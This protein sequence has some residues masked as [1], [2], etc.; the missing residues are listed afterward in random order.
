MSKNGKVKRLKMGLLV[1]GGIVLA[2]LAVVGTFLL[3]SESDEDTAKFETAAGTPGPEIAAARPKRIEISLPSHPIYIGGTKASQSID[4]V[5]LHLVIDEAS[6]KNFVCNRL[7][8]IKD[9]LSVSFGGKEFAGAD[10]KAFLAPRMANIIRRRI[11]RALNTD[12]VRDVTLSFGFQS[13]GRAAGCKSTA[14]K[15]N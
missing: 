15:S 9:V 3:L 11:N 14:K 13:F 12:Y 8:Q 5:N 10:L 7:P 4:Y 1:G 6:H 2:N